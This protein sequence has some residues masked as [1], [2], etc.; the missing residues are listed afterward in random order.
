MRPPEVE[1]EAIEQVA[2]ADMLLLNKCDLVT[3]EDLVEVEKVRN[4]R[5]FWTIFFFLYATTITIDFYICFF[6]LF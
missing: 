1:V 6:W 5:S 2:F 3:E 4:V